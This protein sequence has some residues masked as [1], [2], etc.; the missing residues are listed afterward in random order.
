MHPSVLPTDNR[1]SMKMQR[2]GHSLSGLV[3]VPITIIQYPITSGY[4]EADLGLLQY[5]R[6]SDL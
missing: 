6:W 1:T 4:T 3:W 5:P 2:H